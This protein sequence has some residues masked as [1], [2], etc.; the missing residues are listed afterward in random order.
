MN[1]SYI[2]SWTKVLE[3][4]IQLWPA[5]EK[6]TV[7]CFTAYS[8]SASGKMILADFPP[9]SRVIGLRLCLWEFLITKY[10][11]YVDPVNE[12]LLISLCCDNA[13]PVFPSPVTK[14]ITP[15]GKPASLIKFANIKAVNGVCSAGFKT[16]VQPAARA[17]AH[18]QVNINRG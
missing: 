10:P 16:M 13:S 11:T 17:G 2:S 5:L 3:P 12:T 8:R 4:A 18:F 9:S 15:G 6:T 7:A 14:L 1:L